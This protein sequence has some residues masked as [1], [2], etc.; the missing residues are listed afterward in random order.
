MIQGKSGAVDEDYGTDVSGTEKTM[1]KLIELL[2]KNGKKGLGFVNLTAL[3]IML[4]FALAGLHLAANAGLSEFPPNR[5]VTIGIDVFS[6]FV[7]LILTSAIMLEKSLDRRNIFLLRMCMLVNTNLFLDICCW[8]YEGK[9]EH[10]FAIKLCNSLYYVIGNALIL[11]FWLYVVAELDLKGK[12]FE[13]TANVLNITTGLTTLAIILNWDLGYFFTVS[14]AGVYE[15]TMPWYYFSNISG[16]I[17]MLDSIILIIAVRSIN[18][19]QKAIL[20]T[21]VNFPAI[22]LL[23]QLEFYGLSL[24]YPF[25]LVSMI[26]IYC[27]IHLQR[28]SLINEQQVKLSEQSV[29]LMISQI[30]PHF[31]YNSLTTITNLCRKNPVEAENATVMFSRYLRTNLDSLKKTDPVPFAMELEHI[32]TYLALEKMRFGERLNI[33]YD[34]REQNFTVPALG[35]QPIVENSVKHGICEKG[36]PGTLRITSEKADGGFRVIIEDDGVGFDTSAPVKEDGRSHVGINNVKERL[37]KMCDAE[38]EIESSPG[39]GCKTTVFFPAIKR[40]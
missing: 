21:Y 20:L 40:A 15:R 29:A 17:I 16:V 2:Q 18:R 35:L 13:V 22:G 11:L 33:E 7:G 36:E 38:T 10:A 24:M 37:K 34:I 12:V 32:K 25:F 5:V 6:M 1:N 26:L 14:E 3:L 39:N 23:L 4:A 30:Q 19:S 31:L 28:K 9:A 27:S 8:V